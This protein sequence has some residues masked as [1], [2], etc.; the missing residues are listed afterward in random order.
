MNVKIIIVSAIGGSLLKL[1]L[2]KLRLL[3][4]IFV[5]KSAFL[6]RFITI[7]ELFVVAA[8]QEALGRE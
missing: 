3:K 5:K 1:S 4:C 7:S 8:Y 2:I 6:F